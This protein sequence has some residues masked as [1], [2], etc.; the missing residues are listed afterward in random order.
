MVSWKHIVQID[1]WLEICFLQKVKFSNF[2]WQLFYYYASLV[3]MTKNIVPFFLP[4]LSQ[5]Y[6]PMT[7]KFWWSYTGWIGSCG[8]FVDFLEGLGIFVLRVETLFEALFERGSVC[9]FC[10]AVFSRIYDQVGS[11]VVSWKW[12]QDYFLRHKESN[13]LGDTLFWKESV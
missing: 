5:S 7:W 2:A 6:F 11:A 12:G 3:S 13:L 4:Q 10:Y 1:T 8:G 9:V